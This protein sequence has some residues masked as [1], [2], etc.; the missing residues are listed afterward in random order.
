MFYDD[1]KDCFY[2]MLDSENK[3]FDLKYLPIMPCTQH[4]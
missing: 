3:T 4:T 2:S 1:N